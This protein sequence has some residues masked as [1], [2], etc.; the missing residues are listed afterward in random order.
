MFRLFKSTIADSLSFFK[1][2]KSMKQHIAMPSVIKALD[3]YGLK[4]GKWQ[5]VNSVI[6]EGGCVSRA[7][8]SYPNQLSRMLNRQITS[9][10][11]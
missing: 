6:P 9:L 11:F 5:F 1:P 7:G 3:L 2:T 4:N 8:M 10:S